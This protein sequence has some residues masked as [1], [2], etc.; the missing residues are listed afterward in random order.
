MEEQDQTKADDVDDD[1]DDII[2]TIRQATRIQLSGDESI[3]WCFGPTSNVYGREDS[4]CFSRSALSLAAQ[5][6]VSKRLS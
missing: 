5:A 1:D 6:E 2:S 4:R 3:I